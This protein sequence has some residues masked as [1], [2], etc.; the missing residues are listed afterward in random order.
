MLEIHKYVLG[1]F[2]DPLPRRVIFDLAPGTKVL[3]VQTQGDQITTWVL[4]PLVSQRAK[5]TFH[6]RG[7][8]MEARPEWQHVGTIVTT[9]WVVHVFLEQ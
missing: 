2:S 7:T 4:E 9:T 6:L 5:V 8:G 1:S 3:S